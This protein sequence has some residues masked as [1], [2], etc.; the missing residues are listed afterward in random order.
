DPMAA[1]LGGKIVQAFEAGGGEVTG[2]PTPRI[3]DVG[4]G[5]RGVQMMETDD[6]APG[7]SQP[8]SHPLG[9]RVL[10]KTV[11]T[12]D[13]HAPEAGADAV[14][15][16]KVSGRPRGQETV[17]AGRR[18]EQEAHVDGRRVATRAP[19][20]EPPPTVRVSANERG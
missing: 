17:R 13:V 3:E 6:I 20:V 15:E 4:R 14:R 11:L 8:G 10:W 5:P 18:I 1:K 2:V 9:Q 16:V 12:H 7:A 19:G